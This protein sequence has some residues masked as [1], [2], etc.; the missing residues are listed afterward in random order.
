MSLCDWFGY[1]VIGSV[2][3]VAM[4]CALLVMYALFKAVRGL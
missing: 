3:F 2:Y 4:G 1:L